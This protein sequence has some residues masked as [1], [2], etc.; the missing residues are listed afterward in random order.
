MNQKSELSTFNNSRFCRPDIFSRITELHTSQS[1]LNVQQT[2]LSLTAGT[3]QYKSSL[4]F[5]NIINLHGLLVANTCLTIWCYSVLSDAILRTVCVCWSLL[6]H[7]SILPILPFYILLL[8][9]PP[10]FQTSPV[11]AICYLAFYMTKKI[12]LLLHNPFTMS[13]AMQQIA[14]LVCS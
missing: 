12:Q 7:S 10:L 13:R 4:S 1:L 11:T 9:D 14:I 3:A 2:P 5:I 8:V 6:H